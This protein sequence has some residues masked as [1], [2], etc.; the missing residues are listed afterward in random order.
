MKPG[1]RLVLHEYGLPGIYKPDSIITVVSNED[2][3]ERKLMLYTLPL[4]RQ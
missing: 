4:K 2:A 1:S 3:A